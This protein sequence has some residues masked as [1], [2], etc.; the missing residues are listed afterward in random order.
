MNEPRRTALAQRCR[1]ATERSPPSERAR[2][3]RLRARA[4][5]PPRPR[6]AHVPGSPVDTHHTRLAEHNS[7]SADMDQRFTGTRVDRYPRDRPN[8]SRA[9]R[10]PSCKRSLRAPGRSLRR[11]AGLPARKAG[12]FVCGLHARTSTRITH[13]VNQQADQKRRD[14]IRHL[15]LDLRIS[16]YP[17]WPVSSPSDPERPACPT[18]VSKQRWLSLSPPSGHHAGRPARSH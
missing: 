7:T 16:V 12:G 8:R 11:A 18:A 15:R 1:H 17:Q 2:D 10:P 13:Q 6:R 5:G 4:G 3:R 14:R 9:P